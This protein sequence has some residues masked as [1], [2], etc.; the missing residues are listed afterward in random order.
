MI[1]GEKFS[2]A[3]CS[4]C[5]SLNSVGKAKVFSCHNRKCKAVMSRDE[6]GAINIGWNA[7]LK[8]MDYVD[9]K[10]KSSST[11]NSSGSLAIDNDGGGGGPSGDIQ[12]QTV[13]GGEEVGG[14]S[15][16]K[17]SRVRV[18]VIPSGNSKSS[19][20]CSTSRHFESPTCE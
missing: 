3:M 6:N 17:S 20:I 19:S 16:A 18:S 7:I 15:R 13:D 14:S 2:N 8:L 11:E 5:G 1:V 10:T 9:K 12:N 4:K